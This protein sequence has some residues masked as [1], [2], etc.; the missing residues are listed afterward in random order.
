MNGPRRSVHQQD[1]LAWLAGNPLPEPAGLLLSLPDAVEF[2]HRDTGRWR[3]WFVDAAAAVLR[4]GAPSRG[5]VFFQTDVVRDGVWIDKAHLVLIAAESVSATLRWR[6]IVCRAPAGTATGGRPGYAHLL[7]FAADAD[8]V[9]APHRGADVLPGLGAMAWN[10][11]MGRAAA[12]VAVGWLAARGARTLVA[13]FCGTGTALAVANAN[14][15]DAI[16]IELHAGRAAAA[17]SQ[18]C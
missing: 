14:G 3:T 12:E 5:V 18:R 2:R 10:R 15:L 8:A 7:A 16:G 6:K 1:A 13:P 9:A 17:R 4:A 11:A